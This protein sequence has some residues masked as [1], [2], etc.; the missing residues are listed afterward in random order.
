MILRKIELL[1]IQMRKPNGLE[2][3]DLKLV[4]ADSN[5]TGIKSL[6]IPDLEL[7]RPSSMVPKRPPNEWLNSF[8]NRKNRNVVGRVTSLAQVGHNH[9]L[10]ATAEGITSIYDLGSYTHVRD[11]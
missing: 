1:N 4:T 6:E 3:P 11:L 10:V 2:I 5:L 9:F 8:K 7:S